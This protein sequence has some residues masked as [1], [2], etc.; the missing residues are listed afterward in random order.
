MRE[1]WLNYVTTRNPLKKS[2]FNSHFSI[3]SFSRAKGNLIGS[4]SCCGNA[5]LLSAVVYLTLTSSI[6]G[7]SNVLRGSAKFSSNFKE[8]I[9]KDLIED[10]YLIKNMSIID[11]QSF[12]STI[13]FKL[14]NSKYCKL[15]KL[16]L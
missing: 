13:A 1:R 11:Y 5:L 6:N 12:F 10:L 8:M 14:L 7:C 9:V 15:S 2:S 16:F 3:F 4:D